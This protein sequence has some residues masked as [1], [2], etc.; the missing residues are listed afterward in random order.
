MKRIYILSLALAAGASTPLSAAWDGSATLWN[1]GDGSAE[2]PFLIENEAHF[3]YFQKAV[4]DGEGYEGKYFRLEANLDMEGKEMSTVGIYND[5]TLDNQEYYE[6]KAFLGTF[7]GAYHS[8]DNLTVNFS[9]EEAVGGCGLF[10]VGRAS[11][12]IQNLILGKNVTVNALGASDCGGIIGVASGS[13]IKNCHNKG[14]VNGGSTETG[15]IV[16]IALPGTTIDGCAFSGTV[17]AH[18]FSGGI[19]GTTQTTTVTNCY[20]KGEISAEGA[21][22]A[23]GIVSWA[24]NNSRVEQCYAIGKVTAQ[25]GSSYLPG[26]SP[27]CAEFERSTAADC[28]YVAELCGCEPLAAQKG[29]DAVTA[30]ELKSDATL[31]VLNGEVNPAVWVRGDDGFP[32]LAW[33]SNYTTAVENVFME[34]GCSAKAVGGQIVATANGH[35]VLSIYDCSGRMLYSTIFEGSAS[36]STASGIYVVTV[37]NGA[38]VSVYKLAL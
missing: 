31:A 32:V 21:Y 7:D 5:Y 24:D 10:A 22:F 27:V 14:T 12:T 16:G 18:S 15:G 36:Y 28:F 19:A 3:A 30:D 35:A 13:T 8:I 1:K 33:E 29:V 23:A 6:S 26:Q 4:T 25:P 37:S 34:S 17:N 9:G 20:N 2:N 38:G 11:T